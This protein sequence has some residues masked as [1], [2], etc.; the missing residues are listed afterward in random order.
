M[1]K[2]KAGFELGKKLHENDNKLLKTIGLVVAIVGVAAAVAGIVFA[3]YKI[4]ENAR[5]D[6]FQDDY[7]ELFDDDEEEVLPQK[8]KR[9]KEDDFEDE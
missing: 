4:V 2:F 1:G 7:D 9:A 6:D 3:I 5:Y 8:T